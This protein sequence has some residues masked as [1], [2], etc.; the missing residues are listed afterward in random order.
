MTVSRG[1]TAETNRNI[2]QMQQLI[3]RPSLMPMNP[4]LEEM[5]KQIVKTPN[6]SNHGLF[7]VELDSHID[8]KSVALDEEGSKLNEPH[9]SSPEHD[10]SRLQATQ[11]CSLF[12]SSFGVECSVTG[13]QPSVYNAS[14]RCRKIISEDRI[15]PMDA[16]LL[17]DDQII[18]PNMS[19]VSLINVSNP[20]DHE[21]NVSRRNSYSQSTSQLLMTKPSLLFA[22]IFSEYFLDPVRSLHVQRS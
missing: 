17:M 8:T 12:V 2:R 21:P 16:L 6:I 14:Q 4:N 5:S 22:T 9:R 19:Y 20:I 15:D 1:V 18:K 11:L 13:C 10:L 7:F 3:H